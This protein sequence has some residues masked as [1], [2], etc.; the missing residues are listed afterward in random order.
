MRTL[1]LCLLLLLS[2]ARAEAQYASQVENYTPGANANDPF[3][4]AQSALG[5]PSLN[6]G[7]SEFLGE[8]F[9][10]GD[11]TPFN[12]AFLG[13]QIV[14]VGDGGVLEVSFASPVVDDPRNPFG[15]DL[16]VFGNAFFHQPGTFEPIADEVSADDALISV[17][18]Y[19]STWLD[20]GSGFAD[21]LFPTNGFTD[22]NG[23]FESGGTLE[24]D[25]TRPVDPSIDWLGAD[26]AELVA[27]YAGSGGGGGV[28]LGLLGLPWIQYVR[29]TARNGVTTEID[30]F[31]DV[32]ALPLPEPRSW[33]LLLIALAA[34]TGARLRA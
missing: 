17:S 18:Q 27:L 16:I 19:G 15:V 21:G 14:Q 11:V 24:S 2:A 25:F 5:M 1:T 3:L 4:D 22:T 26:Y 34:G 32:A 29:I 9:D 10:N 13:E 8:I 33:A 20:V 31:A 30:A 12:P 6:N 23:P 7:Y 28:D